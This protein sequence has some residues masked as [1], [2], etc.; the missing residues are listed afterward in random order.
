MKIV[1]DGSILDVS[2]KA[3]E[4]IYKSHG[5]TEYVEEAIKP[6]SNKKAPKAGEPC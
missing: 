5:Y 1:K 3:Y 4:V 6:S 2:E